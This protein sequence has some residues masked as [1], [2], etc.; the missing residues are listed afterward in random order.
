[1][2]LPIT[3]H[4]TEPLTNRYMA[5]QCATLRGVSAFCSTRLY[6]PSLQL[7]E[8]QTVRRHSV[9][10]HDTNRHKRARRPFEKSTPTTATEQASPQSL[11]G[12]R[13]HGH[14]VRLKLLHDARTKFTDLTICG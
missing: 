5:M 13:I 2:P 10:K 9:T 8:L 11:Q 7:L 3:S 4:G 1:M 14:R 12:H 6:D